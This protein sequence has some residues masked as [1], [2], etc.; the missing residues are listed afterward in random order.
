MFPPATSS[1]APVPQ[2][3]SS[4]GLWCQEGG[5]K[6]RRGD[7]DGVPWPPPHIPAET[8]PEGSSVFQRAANFTSFTLWII[9][10][11]QSVLTSQWLSRKVKMEAEAALAP[12]TRERIRPEG[13]QQEDMDEDGVQD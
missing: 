4:V 6:G 9:G 5:K 13:G 1:C 2:T 3:G 7:D 8:Q 11:S 12:R 10:C